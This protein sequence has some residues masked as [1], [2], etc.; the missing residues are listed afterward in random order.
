M[1]DILK[2]KYEDWK[3]Y[4]GK[5]Y[6]ISWEEGSPENEVVEIE[7]FRVIVTEEGIKEETYNLQEYSGYIQEI[8]Q[9]FGEFDD[10]DC[11]IFNDTPADEFRDDWCREISEEK[12]NELKEIIEK[13]IEFLE[14]EHK[15]TLNLIQDAKNRIL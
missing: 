7:I 12:F 2:F 14:R 10:I 11:W 6:I 8:F 1:A 15:I 13:R 5:C 3:P 4:D 9:E